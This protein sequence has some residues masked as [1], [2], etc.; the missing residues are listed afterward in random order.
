MKMSLSSWTDMINSVN[1][2]LVYKGN[3]WIGLDIENLSNKLDHWSSHIL[4]AFP[5]IIET[6]ECQLF[7]FQFL[8]L[9]FSSLPSLLTVHPFPSFS[10]SF[11]LIISVILNI[12]NP[13]LVFTFP[14]HFS[15]F[16][17]TH[18]FTYYTFFV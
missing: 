7:I 4:F 10:S 8:S 17:Y 6:L 3:S 16:Q 9:N 13:N 14:S 1:L 12:L 11:Y 18:S 15:D 2:L 5:S